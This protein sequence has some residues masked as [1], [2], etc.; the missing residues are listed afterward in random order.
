MEINPTICK[1]ENTEKQYIQMMY[2]LIHQFERKKKQ[3]E[4]LSIIFNK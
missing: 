3:A 2:L 1:Y 4:T